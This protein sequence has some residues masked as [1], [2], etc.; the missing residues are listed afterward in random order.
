MALYSK[1]E[2]DK[3]R[4]IA[5]FFKGFD[6]SI[7]SGSSSEAIDVVIGMVNRDRPVVES[8]INPRNSFEMQSDSCPETGIVYGDLS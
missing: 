4:E 1:K 8:L 2:L 5:R 7:R 6:T 3:F